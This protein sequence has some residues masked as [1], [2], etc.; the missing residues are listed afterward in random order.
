[1]STHPE[2][3]AVLKLW[4]FGQP[5]PLA[6][7]IPVA[8]TVRVVTL[9][10]LKVFVASRVSVPSS[11]SVVATKVVSPFIRAVAPLATLNASSTV[12]PPVTVRLPLLTVIS[13]PVVAR[14]TFPVTLVAEP[15]TVN[16]FPLPLTFPVILAEPPLMV[17]GTFIVIPLSE[18]VMVPL[19]IPN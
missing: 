18:T 5:R 19:L 13:A 4:L 11:V 7:M 9:T 17:T 3:V 2:F 6:L 14:L 12:I 1:M 10:S 8:P 15:L 16:K